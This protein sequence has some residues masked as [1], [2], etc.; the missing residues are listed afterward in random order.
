MEHRELLKYL[1]KF[2]QYAAPLDRWATDLEIVSNNISISKDY[3]IHYAIDFAEIFAHVYPK[4]EMMIRIER[5]RRAKRMFSEEQFRKYEIVLAL[6]FEELITPLI[7]SKLILL[8]PYLLE[9]EDHIKWAHSSAVQLGEQISMRGTTGVF[10]QYYTSRD[11]NDILSKERMGTP[12]DEK[13]ANLIVKIAKKG[14]LFN[15]L[16]LQ[17]WKSLNRIRQLIGPDGNVVIL[18]EAFPNVNIDINE[19][20]EN[21]GGWLN[22]ISRVRPRPERMYANYIDALACQYVM[23]INK[24]INKD[25]QLL[26]LISHSYAVH[27]ALGSSRVDPSIDN[28]IK[29]IPVVRSLDQLLAYLIHKGAGNNE[30]LKLIEDSKA[31]ALPFKEFKDRYPKLQELS[32]RE[33]LGSLSISEMNDI[34]DDDVVNMCDKVRYFVDNYEM[35]EKTN[36][37]E[38]LRIASKSGLN[39]FSKY[40][41]KTQEQL[42]RELDK[43]E[44]TIAIQVINLLIN[45]PKTKKMLESEFQTIADEIATDGFLLRR[46]QSLQNDEYKIMR[47]MASVYRLS[48]IPPLTGALVEI[49]YSIQ[50]YSQT[51]GYLSNEIRKRGELMDIQGAR[52]SFN[53]LL[54]TISSGKPHPEAFLL[55]AHL[56]GK[57]SNWQDSLAVMER[58]LGR[59]D[60]EE[61][62]RVEF[63]FW[64]TI[65]LRN[66]KPKTLAQAIDTC[67]EALSI[68]P[69][70]ERILCEKGFLIWQSF[71]TDQGE[72]SIDDAIEATNKALESAR[73]A[74]LNGEP[75]YLNLLNNIAY[76]YAAR[77][78]ESDLEKATKMVNELQ[79]LAETDSWPAI[80]HDTWGF[81]TYLQ[82][83]QQ[84]HKVED[85]LT[86][87]RNAVKLSLK[88][89][90][91]P[92]WQTKIARYH[93]SLI[94]ET[95]VCICRLQK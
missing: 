42:V 57:P 51:I 61:K 45:D 46:L 83:V 75:I 15:L 76:L 34:I 40:F 66:V 79:S 50:F 14:E 39:A 12:L 7:G 73:Y 13:E 88:K 58:G 84:Q 25:Q 59:V 78:H 19:I 30:T 3:E 27:E 63:L 10:P 4:T 89:G 6:L 70:D 21:A 28:K 2:R 94:N 48:R 11:I 16:T 44:V 92:S 37:Y 62:S 33:D 18:G 47:D 49:A 60:I 67:L 36:T 71:E 53:N 29:K 41:E 86:T 20:R 1:D 26:V 77:N 8:P 74:R 52:R 22:M 56:L 69:D 55:L 68:S 54:K 85:I 38:N 90:E 93:L 80:F 32:R 81:V 64:K 95:R 24:R 31:R 23:E 17:I 72:Y 9:L 65:V 43:R 35:S 5:S 87:A 91:M 82:S